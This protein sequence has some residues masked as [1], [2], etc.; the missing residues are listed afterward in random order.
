MATQVKE[1]MSADPVTIE[2]DASALAAF[3][4]MVDHGIRHLPVVDSLERVVG[5]LSIDDLRAALP[6]AAVPGASL[7][8]KTRAGMR[9][10]RVGQLMTF[11]PHTVRAETPLAEAAYLMAELRIGC[12]PVVESE[13]GLVGILSE[14]DAL[15][16]LA[17][18]LWSDEMR[19]RRS[20]ETQL[21]TLVARLRS[22][23]ERIAR[24]VGGYTEVER[25]F[26]THP[27]EEAVDFSERAADRSEA[28]NAG[29]LQAFAAQR[30]EALDRALER[31]EAGRLALC[32][33]CGRRIP[34]VRLQALPGNTLCIACARELEA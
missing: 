22:E 27:Q 16:A 11:E 30:L 8:L 1:W 9:S 7:D 26:T 29:I 10:R 19:A 23:R 17:A 28:E 3:D 21:D 12:L 24:A 5:V 31:A 32:E 25:R 6:V 34:L 13:G 14:T 2:P 20:L 33:R 15:R 4:L 18:T